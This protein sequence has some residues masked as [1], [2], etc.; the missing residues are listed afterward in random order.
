MKK[1]KSLTIKKNI[2]L[3]LLLLIIVSFISFYINYHYGFKGVNPLDNFTNY[4]SGFNFL[5]NKYPFKNFWTA[6]GP[7]LGLTQSFFF[8]IFGINWSS[9]VVHASLFNSIIAISLFLFL[10]SFGVNNILSS[11][12]AILFS[13]IFYPP[14]G[15]PFVDHHSMMFTYLSFFLIIYSLNKNKSYLFL[16]IPIFFLFGFFSKQTPIAYFFLLISPIIIYNL[17]KIR[18]FYFLLLGSLISLTLFIIYINFTQTNLIDIYYQYFIGASEVGNYR[19]KNTPFSYYDVFFRYRFIYLSLILILYF[20]IKDK[21]FSRNFNIS[22]FEFIYLLLSLNFVMILHQLLTMNQAFIFSLIFLNIGLSFKFI[23]YDKKFINNKMFCIL[24]I[25]SFILSLKYHYKYN[26]PRRFNDLAYSN[27]K[28]NIN[29]GKY[30]PSLNNLEWFTQHGDNPK[31]EIEN[32]KFTYNVLKEEKKKYSLI[33]DYQ[34]LPIELGVYGNSPIKWFHTNVSFPNMD[35]QD[36]IDLKTTFSN[37]FIKQ[38]KNESIEKI[39]FVPPQKTRKETVI[40]ITK[41]RCK[42]EELKIL[43]NFYE[44]LSINCM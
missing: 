27:K 33:T 5:N 16:F 40:K 39:Y 9:Y 34:F 25:F 20:L 19:L 4:N 17:K 26:E 18:I 30:F 32:L 14:V 23:K 41:K 8:K 37:F 11:I 22:K 24:I 21:N 38:I 13:I 31:K 15:T 44:E 12:F 42:I 6:T 36:N 1:I 43:D 3:N 7:F 35:K 29:A 2:N 28:Q 10:V